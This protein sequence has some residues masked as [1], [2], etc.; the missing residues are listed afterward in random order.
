MRAKILAGDSN[1]SDPL[2]Q[3]AELFFEADRLDSAAYSI[4]EAESKT[5]AVWKKFTAAKALQMPNERRLTKTGCASDGRKK[6]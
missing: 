5:E 2:A 3:A 4:L 1:R 6:L